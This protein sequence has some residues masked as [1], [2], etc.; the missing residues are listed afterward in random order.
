[1]VDRYIAVRGFTKEVKEMQKE[2]LDDWKEDFDK[3]VS[4]NL[5]TNVEFPAQ[6]Y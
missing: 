1:M 4:L 3:V 5:S 6:T 2:E